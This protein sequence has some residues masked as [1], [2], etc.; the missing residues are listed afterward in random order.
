MFIEGF[1]EVG[2]TL[3]RHVADYTQH[4]AVSTEFQSG[5]DFLGGIGEIN[6]LFAHSAAGQGKNFFYN[7]RFIGIES[8]RYPDASSFFQSFFIIVDDNGDTLV[9]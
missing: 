4:S 9:I 7:V 5:V 3:G 6:D 8:V 1:F 2:E